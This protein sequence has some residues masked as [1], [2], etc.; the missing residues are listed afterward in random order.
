M[1]VPWRFNSP[2]VINWVQVVN[3]SVSPQ[4]KQG[5]AWAFD[6]PPKGQKLHIACKN[7]GAFGKVSSSCILLFLAFS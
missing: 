2:L 4:W 7:K 3:Q 1:Q 6:N 5:F